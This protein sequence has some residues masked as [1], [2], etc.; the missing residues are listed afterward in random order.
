M[1][2]DPI[3]ISI[4]VSLV[5]AAASIALSVLL[6]PKPDLEDAKPK[7]LGD[8]KFP[9]AIEGRSIP[10]IWGRVKIEGPN[11][12]WYGD[13]RQT[14]ISQT[15]KTGM[16]SKKDVTTGFRYFVGFQAAVCRGPIDNWRQIW[17]G[18]KVIST[19][20]KDEGDIPI[21][22][23]NLFGGD[24]F[25]QGGLEGTLVVR[26]G[27]ETQTATAYLSSKLG[28]LGSIAYRGTA[29]CVW[30]GGWIGNS[31]SLKPWKFEVERY[32]NQLGLASNKHIVNSADANPACVLYEIL[33]G[34]E[35]GMKEAVAD[36]DVSNFQTAGNTLFDEGQGFSM[37]LDNVRNVGEVMNE[38]QRQIDG[39][40]YIDKL[41]GKWTIALARGGYDIDTVTQLTEADLVDVKDLTSGT[42]E[43]TANQI[44]IEYTDRSR[45]YFGTFAMAPDLANLRMQNGRVVSRKQRYPGIKDKTLANKIATREMKMLGRPLTRATVLVDR[46]F[47][48]TTPLDIIAWSDAEFGISKLPMRVIKINSGRLLDGNIELTLVQDVF[49]HGDAFMADPPPTNWTDPTQDV[50]AIPTAQSKVIEAPWAL[51]RRDP[52]FPGVRDR[53]WC[54]GRHQGTGEITFKT[55][56]RNDAGVPSGSYTL[57]GEIDQFLLLGVLNANIDADATTIQLAASPDTLDVLQ[58]GFTTPA[59]AKTDIGQNLV[60][61]IMIEDEFVGVTTVVNQTTYLDL[62]TSYRG[63][64]DSV[65]KPHTAGVSIWLIMVGGGIM[66]D[67]IAQTNNVDVQLRSV[68]RDDETTEGEATDIEITMANRSRRPYPPAALEVNGVSFD[69]PVDPDDVKSGGSGED[70]KGI[71]GDWFRRD[72]R[73]FDEVQGIE[74]DAA[75][76]Q[77]DFPSANS[78]ENRMELVE[79]D[80][81]LTTALDAF[82]AL[83]EATGATRLDSTASNIDL[84]DNNTVNQVSAKIGNGALFAASGSDYL[85]AASAASLDYGDEDFTIAGWFFLVTKS[86]D[87]AILSKW[88]ENSDERQWRLGYDTSSDRFRFSISSDGTAGAV[89]TVDADSFGAVSISTWYFVTAWHD[90]ADNTINI[91]VNAGPIDS[92]VHAGGSNSNTDIVRMGADE[93]GG[94]VASFFDGRA[95]AV[96]VWNRVLSLSEQGSLY[97]A[98]TG[99]EHPFAAR[100]TLATV[101]W[102]A[103]KTAF[104]SR[105]EICEAAGGS[106]PLGE[107]RLDIAARHTFEST[108]YENLEELPHVFD[109][110]TS[111]LDALDALGVLPSSTKSK[112]HVV[113]AAGP[114]ILN[115]EIG[116]ALGGD[117]EYRKNGGSWVQAIAAASTTGNTGATTFVAGDTVEVQH[118][119][120]ASPPDRTIC[121]IK[122]AASANEAYAIIVPS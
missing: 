4:I 105:T 49:E 8:F 89:T 31:T 73:T 50:S 79:N 15:V 110:D 76:F 61:L 71:E 12:T 63:L 43:E 36:I 6:A 40:L 22:K 46:S 45:D 91:R 106:L 99:Q 10:L 86:A 96:G 101:G 83:E 117:V 98:G 84:A 68:S 80:E 25:G 39:I 37:V 112:I 74:S 41:T 17:V 19:T 7:D 119:D 92:A 109:L 118:L 66:D 122:D 78:H 33:I 94:S 70:D 100:R 59:P 114:G 64:L 88:G 81:T 47:W 72:Y 82:W 85:D 60:N 90:T 87:M 62:G 3:T 16:F 23:P 93:V 53:I 108:V 120:G 103:I 121:L 27:T 113:V 18:D 56:Q 116:T 21:V 95:D 104:V 20:V 13:F 107:L 1:A 55:Y 32:P 51:A 115:F 65:Q 52:S 75:D 14:S 69:D 111:D 26:P 38:I 29:Y 58:A 34:D 35:W 9:T 44:R 24:E 67:A 48:N 57:S 30:E 28:S 77:G 11:I 2:I 102:S 42:W 54:G 5:V 97:A